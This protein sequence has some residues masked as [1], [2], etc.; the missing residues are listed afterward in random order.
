MTE[1]AT[2]IFGYRL[3]CKL[4]AHHLFMS[5]VEVGYLDIVDHEAV[6]EGRGY[7][8]IC[9]PKTGYH[10]VKYLTKNVVD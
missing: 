3:L 7:K 9:V 5:V 4:W 2:I 1:R 6:G 10:Q 8:L